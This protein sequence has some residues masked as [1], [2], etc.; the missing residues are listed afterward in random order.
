MLILFSVILPSF[1]L[2]TH[3]H[4]YICRHTYHRCSE[5][6]R[7]TCILL[8]SCV[9]LLERISCSGTLSCFNRD[10]EKRRKKR[11]R[12][13]R[14]WWGSTDGWRCVCRGSETEGEC[15]WRRGHG[16]RRE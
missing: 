10:T 11:R 1:L 7:Q 3:T 6:D 2:H 5:S 12:R 16:G 14:W 13:R 15:R 4:T 8:D 9:S